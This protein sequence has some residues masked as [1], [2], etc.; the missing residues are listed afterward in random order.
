MRRG[1]LA[2]FVPYAIL[3]LVFPY[4]FYSEGPLHTRGSLLAS[5]QDDITNTEWLELLHLFSV[6]K[7]LYLS[8][9]S[10]HSC[11]AKPCW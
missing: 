9:E 7:S 5:L 6:V 1:S 3:Y 2:A 4:T 8:S 11:L 10:V